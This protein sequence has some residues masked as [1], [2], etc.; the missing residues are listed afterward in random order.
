MK[1]VRHALAGLTVAALALS[2][3]AVPAD[4]K[5]KRGPRPAKPVVMAPAATPSETPEQA[6]LRL[7]AEQAAAAKAQN[8]KNAANK[9]AYEAAVAQQKADAD[10]ARAKWLADTVP[11]KDDPEVRCVKPASK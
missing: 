11:C 3:A 2:L 1:S 6:R 8:D 9:A 5:V 4:A 10:A 7:N